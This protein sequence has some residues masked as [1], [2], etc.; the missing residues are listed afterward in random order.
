[1][2]RAVNVNE[3]GLRD[4]I[5]R[6]VCRTNDHERLRVDV[7]EAVNDID[8]YLPGLGPWPVADFPGQDCRGMRKR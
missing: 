4:G 5:L 8:D 2:I 7:M 3:G 1:M 6:N